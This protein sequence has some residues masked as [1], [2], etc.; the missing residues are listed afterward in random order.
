LPQIRPALS[1]DALIRI[2]AE[3]RKTHVSD[4]LLDYTQGLIA[5][6]RDRS[7]LKLGLSPRAGQGLIRASQAWAFL[8]SRRAGGVALRRCTS[9]RAS[10][11]DRKRRITGD[12]SRAHS[13]RSSTSLE[14]PS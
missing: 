13:S 12:R 5:R 2:Q 8:A 4:A 10:R 9:P 7:D 1:P 6:T 3:A 14:R 11:V